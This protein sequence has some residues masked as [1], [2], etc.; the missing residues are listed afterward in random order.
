MRC[1]RRQDRTKVPW[2]EMPQDFEA[3]EP[4]KNWKKGPSNRREGYHGV[5]HS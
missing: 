1:T 2:P 5:R 4:K 3:W